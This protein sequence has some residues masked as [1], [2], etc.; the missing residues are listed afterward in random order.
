MGSIAF[1]VR[2]GCLMATWVVIPPV[3]KHLCVN[4]SATSGLEFEYAEFYFVLNWLCVMQILSL[5]S[6]LHFEK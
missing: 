3:N 2:P 5:A 4:E 6:F 1:A